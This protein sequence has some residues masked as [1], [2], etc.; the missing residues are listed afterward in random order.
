[1]AGGRCHAVGPWS[2]LSYDGSIQAGRGGWPQQLLAGSP[3]SL[4]L[5]A[6]NPLS[7]IHSKLTREQESWRS[8]ASRLGAPHCVYDCAATIGFRVQ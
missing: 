4:L 2:P 6:S 5:L 7:H 8:N 1:M 3:R